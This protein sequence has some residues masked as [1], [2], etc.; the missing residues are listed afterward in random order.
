MSGWA[1]DAAERHLCISQEHA[2]LIKDLAT[3]L[4]EV[5]RKSRCSQVWPQVLNFC[6]GGP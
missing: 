6:A 5:H 4:L 2:V 3:S 1:P